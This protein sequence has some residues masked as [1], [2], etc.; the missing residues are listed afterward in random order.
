MLGK[1]VAIS[2]DVIEVKLNVDLNKVQN[3]INLYVIIEDEL[4]QVVGEISNIK[5]D[6][7]YVNILGQLINN[8]FV[9]GIVTKPSFKASIKIISN[10]K[11]PYIIGIEH[12]LE[13]KH[14]YLGVSPIYTGVNIGIKIDDFFAHHFAIFGSTG[15]GKSC[16]AARILQNLFEKQEYIAYR[17]NMFLF[18][19][20]GEYTTAFQNINTKCP[21]INFKLYTTNLKAP[22]DQLLKI[23]IWLLTVDDLALLLNAEKVSQLPVIE[24]ALKLVSVFVKEGINEN[25]HKNDIIART[26]LDILSSGK[27]PAQMRDQVFSILTYYNTK[28]LNLDAEIFQ[29]GYVRPVK[30]CLVIDNT[31]KIREMELLMTFFT[32]FLDENLELS[33]PDGSFKYT[34]KDLK[35]AFDFALIS[36][37]IFKSDRVYDEYNSLKVRLDSL[38]N[39]DYSVYFDCDQYVNMEQYIKSLLTTKNKRKAQLVNF[40]INY[41]DD[42]FAKSIT[43]IYSRILFEYAKGLDKR[44]SF[45]IHIILEE[46]H[47]YV[48]NDNDI[49]LIGYNIFDRITKE[50]RKYAVV[51]GFISQRPSELSET[52]LSQCGNFL[53][54]KMIHPKD[55]VFIEDV[56]PNI[57]KELTKKLKVLPPGTCVAFGSAFK[58]PSL[59][60][61][62]M[63]SPAPSSSSALI[64]DMWFIEK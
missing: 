29:P 4:K 42:R 38:V 32:S 26:I 47:R 25:R 19:A 41:V 58:I 10:D 8:R 56:L 49:N 16:G 40:N 31:G 1:I 5:N 54:Y 12:Y 35:D 53:I 23:P 46:A 62:A 21:D 39:G 61:M 28:E 50:G 43:K 48:Q 52:C 7:A 3:L 11:V 59:I 22:A 57:T 6:I 36:E 18:D 24:K 37:G 44:A 14:L 20:Y 27:P 33:M 13:N 51:M 15:T 63:P 17:C 60:K 64:S 34:L 55:L 30:Q 45:P 2:E 9:F